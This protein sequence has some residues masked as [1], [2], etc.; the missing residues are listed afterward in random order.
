[1]HTT[2]LLD[3]L[4]RYVRAFAHVWHLRK[5]MD[6]PERLP[7]ETQFLP[8]ALALQ[9]TPIHPAPRWAMRA[10]LL[11]AG[12]AL[13]WAILGQMEIVAVAPGK[14]IPNA[15]TKVIQ[16][17][18]TAKVAAIRVQEG[19]WVQEGD[20]LVE[21]DAAQPQADATRLTGD[22]NTARLGVARAR[23]LLQ[24]M[25]SAQATLPTL[26]DLPGIPRTHL[27]DERRLMEGQ[28]REYRAKHDRLDAEI[29]RRRAEIETTQ[30]L[31]NKLQQTAPI[32]RSRAADFKTLQDQGFVSRHGY[33]E[34]EQAAIEQERDLA[35]QRSK[36][37]ELRA[38]LAEAT[39]QRASLTAETRR[40]LM[41]QLRQ[42][43]TQGAALGQ[44][45]AKADNRRGAMHLT[46]SVAGH[47]QQLAIHTIGGVVTPAQT[48]MVIVPQDTQL[49]VEAVLQNKDIG[50]VKPGQ[51]AEV[52]IETFPYTK[53]GT[54]P[55][56][57]RHVS[58]DAIQDE[59][60]GLIYTA[61][62]KLER[63][64][65]NVDGR[66]V[67]L[68]PGMAVTVE[69][70]TGTRRVIEYFLAP[71]MQVSQESLRER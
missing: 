63:T 39:H 41:D 36:L 55:G 56:E 17:L 11:F 33:L 13:A 61:R 43:S 24:G 50:F 37:E 20:L 66:P 47:V 21:L 22:R 44:E 67:R 49:E 52:K 12:L 6:P 59:K 29:A 9:E 64:T 40:Q 2:A 38:N 5:A 58:S 54:L 8:A 28:F 71:L 18:E 14:I 35:A 68:T 10:I 48:L 3:L 69:A 31:V 46:A 1:M 4:K 62:I 45:L 65:L 27:E 60:L 32:A 26:S 53:Y 30:E 34:K 70:K 57:V 51:R 42:D 23:A 19:Q 16:P 7:H 15:R 25:E